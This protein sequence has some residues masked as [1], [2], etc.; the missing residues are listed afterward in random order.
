MKETNLERLYRKT[1]ENLDAAFNL[2]IFLRECEAKAER[3]YLAAY[4]KYEEVLRQKSLEQTITDCE[5]FANED[6][7]L[8]S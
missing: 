3:E 8:G 4:K 2:L 5:Q 7:T 1:C 6:G